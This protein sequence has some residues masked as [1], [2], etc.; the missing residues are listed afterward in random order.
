M[1][2]SD[3]TRAENSEVALPSVLACCGVTVV[4]HGRS[5][6]EGIDCYCYGRYIVCGSSV[7]EGITKYVVRELSR[8]DGDSARWQL[9]LGGESGISPGARLLPFSVPR[10]PTCFASGLNR[11]RAAPRLNAVLKSCPYLQGSPQAAPAVAYAQTGQYYF[12]PFKLFASGPS[13]RLAV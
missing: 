8:D 11:R 4:L 5:S 1:A 3:L 9:F 2:E 6:M 7:V 12:G 13:A 10:R